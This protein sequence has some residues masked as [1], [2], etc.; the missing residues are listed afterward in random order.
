MTNKNG[1]FGKVETYDIPIVYASSK[2]TTQAKPT[3]RMSARVFEFALDMIDRM[4]S[5][6]KP[7]ASKPKPKRAPLA[8][9]KPKTHHDLSKALDK[10]VQAELVKSIDLDYEGALEKVKSDRPNLIKELYSVG[11]NLPGVKKVD[12]YPDKGLHER[13]LARSRALDKQIQ[14]I[15]AKNPDL[16]YI[17]AFEQVK[18]DQPDIVERVWGR[19]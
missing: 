10:Y 18:S 4:I 8:S 12:R 15:M 2:Q 5:K 14:S 3:V 1:L 9:K 17:A 6:P 19:K 11:A 13:R 7:V 16:D